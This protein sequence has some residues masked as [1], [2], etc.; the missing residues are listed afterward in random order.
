[1][2]R[3]CGAGR[4]LGILG[5]SLL[6]GLGL[7]ACGGGGNS[8]QVAS[9]GGSTTTTA[10]PVAAGNTAAAYRDGL[11]Y[12]NCMRSHGVANFPDPN[13]KGDFLSVHGVLN[14]QKIDINSSIYKKADKECQHL[15]PNGGVATTAQLQ[16]ALAAALKWAHCLQTHGDP[17]FP[18]PFSSNGGVAVKVGSPK[19]PAFAKAAKVC[20]ET[21]QGSAWNAGG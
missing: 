21:P 14:G 20:G 17:S 10:A 13:S 4:R 16:K 1:M 2:G 11:N 7:A 5:G 12:S 9:L 19:D 6:L 15:L 18:D 3:S 8:P